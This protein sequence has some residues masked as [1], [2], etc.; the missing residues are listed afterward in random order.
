M[1][2][3]LPPRIDRAC[4]LALSGMSIAEAAAELSVSVKTLRA[5]LLEAWQRNLRYRP[6]GELRKL[7]PDVREFL[8]LPADWRVS[9]RNGKKNLR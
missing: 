4:T 9:W 5:Y 8:W 6:N 3:Q 2:L 7:A 1:T